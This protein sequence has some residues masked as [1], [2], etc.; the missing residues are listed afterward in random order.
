MKETTP[1]MNLYDFLRPN[2]QHIFACRDI[3]A[4][5]L[6]D[7]GIRVG[8]KRV[9]SIAEDLHDAGL[10][11][12]A[13]SAMDRA[14]HADFKAQME[15][16]TLLDQLLESYRA[17][18]SGRLPQGRPDLKKA[19]QAWKFLDQLLG[20][21]DHEHL[22]HL[23]E[24]LEHVRDDAKRMMDPSLNQRPN[25]RP[26]TQRNESARSIYIEL[27]AQGIPQGKAALLI[28]QMFIQA[29]YANGKEPQVQAAVLD[30]IKR[31]EK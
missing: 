23:I 28:A 4:R 1:S 31:A 27:K 9:R 20:K 12:Q 10:D 22:D 30:A 7:A 21:D 26:A 2:R 11:P 14:L 13:E 5:V 16:V 6:E 25:H 18:R 24:L 17:E 29:G 3:V 8:Q 19:V 15:R